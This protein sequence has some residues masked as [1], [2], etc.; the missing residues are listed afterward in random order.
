[1]NTGLTN[2]IA[3]V[4]GASRGLGFAVARAL[5]KE[6]AKVSISSRDAAAIHAAA[7]KI[8]TETG[9]D[10][11]ATVTGLRMDPVVVV[12]GPGMVIFSFFLV[13]ARARRASP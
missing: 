1:M 5:A 13:W 8:R 2:K 12:I 4:A 6:G 9:A 3:M 7:D 10:V 11:L